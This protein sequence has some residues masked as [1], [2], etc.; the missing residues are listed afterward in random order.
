VSSILALLAALPELLKLL[1]EL[2]RQ[3]QERADA[4]KLKEDIKVIHEAFKE[5]DA[6]K[7]NNLFKSE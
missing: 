5:K 2:Q 7:L 4:A 1:A 6:E 3:S